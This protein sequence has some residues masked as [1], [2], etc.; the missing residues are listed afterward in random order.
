VPQTR[1]KK[2]GG[3]VMIQIATVIAAPVTI[4]SKRRG[5]GGAIGATGGPSIRVARARVDRAVRTTTAPAT[6]T[7]AG[8]GHDMNG[9]GEHRRDRTCEHPAH[10]RLLLC[11]RQ[12]KGF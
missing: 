1:V 6:T 4:N 9:Q 7:S 12:Y 8:L 2:A 3:R 11:P 10:G 5:M